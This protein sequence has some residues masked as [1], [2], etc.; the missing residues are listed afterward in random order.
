MGTR[1]DEI[2]EAIIKNSKETNKYNQ[3]KP[4]NLD[5]IQERDMAELSGNEFNPANEYDNSDEDTELQKIN[6]DIHS[7]ILNTN[8]FNDKNKYE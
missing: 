1:L 4:Y 2:N 3:I 7:D 5:Y 8:I 6:N